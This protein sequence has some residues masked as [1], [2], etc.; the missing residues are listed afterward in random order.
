M[1]NLG[2]GVDELDVEL[3]GLPGLGGWED[4][5][6]EHN[7]SLL[8]SSNTSLDEDEV[9]VDHSVVRESSKWGDVLVNG[10]GSSGSVV[11][12]ST[13][14]TGSNSVH[15]LVKL[16]SAVVTHL[17]STGNSPLDCRWMPGSNTSDLSA[18]SVRFALKSLDCESLHHTLGSLT[19]GHS[20]HVKALTVLKHLRHLNLL[21]EALLGELDLVS[22]GSSIELDL[23][24]VSLV[25]SETKLADLSGDDDTDNGAVL[26]NA[27][28]VLGNWLLGSLLISVGILGEGL[29][30]G[31]GP[32]LVESSLHILVEVLG[33]DGG[34]S[35]ETTWGHDVSNET[36]NFDG[37]GLNDR[38]G[39]Y[40]ISVDE[41]LTLTTLLD[42]DNVGH[43]G[44]VSNEGSEMDLLGC[45]VLGEGSDATSVMSG[46]SHWQESLGS[47]SWMLKLSV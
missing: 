29:L 34:Q 37:W 44:L 47:M 19:L 17:T 42:L 11:S 16:G 45:V 5:L 41:L 32:V 23:H 33:P 3:L 27:G 25:L 6:T 18:T 26:L 8:G 1:T 39:V 2:G 20:N 43:T 22:N 46:T 14:S 15:L 4:G 12:A 31:L 24:D 40:P 30:L 36:N 10:I 9:F 28:S 38:D 7:W 35:A 13:N 21:L